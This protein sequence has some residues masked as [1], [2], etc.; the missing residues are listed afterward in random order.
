MK[1]AVAL[2]RFMVFEISEKRRVFYTLY[3]SD[4]SI[5]E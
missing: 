4:L 5:E 3:Y 1:P 2:A